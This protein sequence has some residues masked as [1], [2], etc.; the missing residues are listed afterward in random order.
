MLTQ[1]AVVHANTLNTLLLLFAQQ[2]IKFRQAASLPII[3]HMQHRAPHLISH[4]RNVACSPTIRM[5]GLTTIILAG[6]V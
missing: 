6:W 4:H 1:R 3:S 2:G 5:A